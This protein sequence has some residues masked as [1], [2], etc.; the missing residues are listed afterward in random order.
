MRRHSGRPGAEI[1]MAGFLREFNCFSLDLGFRIVLT[2]YHRLSFS[3][4]T[5][6]DGED[7]AR[8]APTHEGQTLGAVWRLNEAGCATAF[9]K[10]RRPVLRGLCCWGTNT[11]SPPFDKEH[12][13]VRSIKSAL[14]VL[15]V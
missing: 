4:N 11:V 6:L 14:A 1:R 9:A 15:S 8:A 13:T 12:H 3:M 10:P 5:A 2:V 7:T